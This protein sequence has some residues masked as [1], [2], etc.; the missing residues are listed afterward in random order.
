MLEFLGDFFDQEVKHGFYIDVT[1]KTLWAAE[2]EVLQKVAEICDRHGI[3]WYAAYGT[4]LG[5]VRHGGFVPWDDDMD[6]WVKRKDYNRLVQILPMELPQGY[7]VRCSLAEEKYDQFHTCVNS[8]S[9]INMN[10]E[11]L[12]QYHGCPF[13]VGLDIFPL[14]YLPRDEKDRFL[15]ENLFSVVS[16]CALLAGA[17]QSAEKEGMEEKKRSTKAEI[18]EGVR[19]LEEDCGIQI[20][21]QFIENEDWEQAVSELWKW[22]NYFAM[23]YDEE[24]SDY[25][26]QYMDY[27]RWPSKKFH[28]EYFTETYGASFE[29]FLLPVPCGY[30]QIL[31]RIYGVYEKIVKKTGTHEYPY[32]AR[33]LRWLRERVHEKE[34]R[35]GEL[36]IVDIETIYS[37]DREMELPSNW[38]KRIEGSN[39]RKKIV[40]FANDIT[41]FVENGE[42]AFTKLSSVLR[43]FEDVQ[44]RIVLWWRPSKNMEERLKMVSSVFAEKY[45][46]ILNTYKESQWGICDETDNIDRAVMW[47][48]VYFGDMNPILQPF[49]N[50]NKPVMLETIERKESGN[51]NWRKNNQERLIEYRAFLS[52]SDYAVDDKRLYFSNTNY[53]AL[54]IVD[55]ATWMVEQMIP[56]KGENSITSNIHSYCIKQADKIC[57]LPAIS[58]GVHIYDITEKKQYVYDLPYQYTE[59][60]IQGKWNF[61]IYESQIYLLPGYGRQRLLRWNVLENVLEEEM[62]WGENLPETALRHGC[63]DNDSF[64]TVEVGTNQLYI[65]NMHNRLTEA[66]SLPDEQVSIAYD[67][68]N[69]WYAMK[70]DPQKDN[71]DI[72]CWNQKKGTL[73]RYNISKDFGLESGFEYY[74]EIYF[75][76]GRLII[77]FACCQKIYVLDPNSGQMQTIHSIHCTRGAF[78]WKEIIPGFKAIG[79][80]LVCMLQN[81][82]DIVFIDLESL[83]V[84]QYS[85]HFNMEGK[86]EYSYKIAL[87]RNALLYEEPNK[88]GTDT[89]ISYCT[90]ITHND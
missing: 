9:G 8:G 24:E 55:K 33:Q 22:A 35:A 83:E 81:A 32:Y 11:W 50:A 23:M 28:K 71:L 82:G 59:G 63:I 2:L 16:H 10:S 88:V 70:D 37:S 4:L 89:L 12:E 38:N 68:E 62:W 17:I 72:V 52:M 40:L 54:V 84:K 29:N 27:I 87:S 15:Q 48:D 45:R 13:T 86:E 1:M 85:A 18:L 57:F 61:F 39:G 90:Q 77:F 25:L 65:T 64:Y 49:Q 75:A 21:R 80:T 19:Y 46:Q 76:A 5:A 31:H 60:K 47:C 3:T 73:K 41:F 34:I 26:V 14:D 78:Q 74:T 43:T 67:G 6:I 58:K 66:I 79:N 69:F 36:G 44:D 53:N 7:L 42:S 30:E 20:N 56:F 51:R